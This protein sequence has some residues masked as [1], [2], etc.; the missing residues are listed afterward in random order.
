LVEA[1]TATKDEEGKK[2]E[3][4]RKNEKTTKYEK[5]SWGLVSRFVCDKFIKRA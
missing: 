5:Y 4:E 2:N 3:K 1:A